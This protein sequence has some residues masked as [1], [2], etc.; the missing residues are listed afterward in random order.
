[1]DYGMV[2]VEAVSFWGCASL[3]DPFWQFSLLAPEWISLTAVC[4]RLQR[5][6]RKPF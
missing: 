4:Q 2:E 1:M 3:I 6:K 5:R